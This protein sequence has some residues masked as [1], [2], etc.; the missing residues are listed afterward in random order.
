LQHGCKLILLP[1]A[2][3]GLQPAASS[4]PTTTSDPGM[5]TSVAFS[6]ANPKPS[7]RLSPPT[8]PS[9]VTISWESAA[10][11]KQQQVNQEWQRLGKGCY[12]PYQLIILPP[13]NQAIGYR[14][15]G[16]QPS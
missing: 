10:C 14:A 13:C 7:Q 8:R 9:R 2:V 16:Q 5:S 12:A 3:A 1:A 15:L 4:S 11:S 6:A